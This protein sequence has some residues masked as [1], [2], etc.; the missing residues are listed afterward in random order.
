MNKLPGRYDRIASL[1]HWLI[2]V[3]LLGQIV[4]G[5]LLDEIA[6]RGTPARGSVINLH[7]SLGLVLGALIVLRLLWRLW[8]RPPAWPQA[9][10][11]WQ[12]RAAALGHRALY[13]CMVL[14]PASGYIASNFSKHGIKLF[15]TP[16]APWGPDIPI[17]YAA[18][19]L[20][21]VATAWV[22][23]ALIVGHVA[24]ALKHAFVDRE[25]IFARIDPRPPA[26]PHLTTSRETA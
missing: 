14:M 23:T 25:V 21:H 7:K 11:N 16:L 3:A 6:P 9:M 13:A 20:L 18:F 24:V 15:G 4:F 17:V 12:R 5:F 19:N 10:P 8:H 22:F 1:L 26:P 2:G